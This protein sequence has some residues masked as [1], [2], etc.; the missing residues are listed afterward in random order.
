MNLQRIYETHPERHEQHSGEHE[1]TLRSAT[2]KKRSG[3]APFMYKQA[4]L[5]YLSIIFIKKTD[6][7]RSKQKL[8]LYLP[9]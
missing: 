6:K 3:A 5:M 7:T 4:R 8:L 2:A 1:W 9:V